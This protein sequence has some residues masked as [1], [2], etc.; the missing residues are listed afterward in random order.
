[1]FLRSNQTS[2]IKDFASEVKVKRGLESTCLDDQ[3][4]EIGLD[5][6]QD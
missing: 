1:M 6:P 4:T 2:K 3:G 5:G